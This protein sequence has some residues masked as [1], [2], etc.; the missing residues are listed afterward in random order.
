MLFNSISYA[1]FLAAVLG[2]NYIIPKKF[3]YIWLLISSYFFYG[4]FNV[5]YTALLFAITV[6]TYLAALIIEKRDSIKNQVM[7][8]SA[9]ACFGVLIYFKYANFLISNI[10]VVL[11]KTG[12]GKE[13]AL[14][15][16]ILPV[17]ISFYI[18]QAMGYVIDVYRGKIAPEKNFLYYALFVAFFPQ[19]AAGPIGR[20]NS[21]IPQIHNPNEMTNDRLREGLFLILLGL[22]QKLLIADNITRFV[23][24]VFNNYAKYT[25]LEI[26]M[27]V[28]MFGVQIY[29]DFAGYSNM[30]IGSAKLLGIDLMQNFA[31]PYLATSVVDFWKRW[32][33]SLTSWFTDYIYIPLG[34]NRKGNIRRYI[35]IMIVFLVSGAWHGAS[36]NFI[37]WGGLN[38]V[39][40]IFSGIRARKKKEN[41]IVAVSKVDEMF[42][43]VGTF[44]LIDFSWLFFRAA[45]LGTAFGMIRKS[46]GY[47]GLGPLLR[48]DSFEKIFGSSLNMFIVIA[49][50]AL[51]FTF[52]AIQDKTKKLFSYISEQ[53]A[54]WRWLVYIMLITAIVLFGAYGE[55]YSQNNFIYFQ[56]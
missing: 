15:N 7:A 49:S 24:P 12:S 16:I 26:G 10:Q 54:V 34:G 11:N 52:D 43:R 22:W 2:V 23:D 53:K 4:Y 32:H 46:V 9:I 8:I 13:L 42:R 28:L 25:G 55:G 21:L 20:A 56:F 19:L 40:N 14:L 47:I 30:A 51:L 44:L 45:S 50:V 33:I 36:W 18:F 17:G 35:N 31:A 37:F 1:A 6:I 27:A 5:K 39:F 3:R 38:G 29:C 41:G 48:G